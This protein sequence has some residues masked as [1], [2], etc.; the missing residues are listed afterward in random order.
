MSTSSRDSVA[1]LCVRITSDHQPTIRRHCP[2]CAAERHFASSGKFRVN[3]QK[4][5]IDAWLI[6]L[7]TECDY[8]LNQPVH[9]RRP[10]KSIDPVG[11]RAL[12]RND[13]ALADRHA[14]ASGATSEVA[15]AL[16]FS[17]PA[18]PETSTIEMTIAVA[19]SCC[20]RLDRLLSLILGLSRA[21]LQR[22]C[23]EA[24]VSIAPLSSKALRRPAIDGQ[25]VRLDLADCPDDLARRCRGSLTEGRL[26]S[27]ASDPQG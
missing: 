17:T 10:L 21:E 16:A 24:T 23:D 8:R 11:L 20:I 12:M 25:T 9:E 19:P 3:A 1:R 5:T 2:R 4:K 6:F 26:N 18:D 22:L 13:R 14:A 7:C 27:P 15:V